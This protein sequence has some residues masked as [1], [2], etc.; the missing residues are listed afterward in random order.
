MASG[1][2]A[3]EEEVSGDEVVVEDPADVFRA[4]SAGFPPSRSRTSRAPARAMADRERRMA[5]GFGMG[6]AVGIVV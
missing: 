1:R 4:M 6:V 3:A 2:E 5:W